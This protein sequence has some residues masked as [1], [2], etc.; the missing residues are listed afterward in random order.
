MRLVKG[1]QARTPRSVIESVGRCEGGKRGLRAQCTSGGS[2]RASVKIIRLLALAA[3]FALQGKKKGKEMVRKQTR[4]RCGMTSPWVSKKDGM[5]TSQESGQNPGSPTSPGC[6][7]TLKLTQ[8][9]RRA[10]RP[11]KHATSWN[12]TPGR[13]GKIPRH[14]DRFSCP[15]GSIVNP[16]KDA[17]SCR[18]VGFVRKEGKVT[19][20]RLKGKVD[21]MP[22]LQ[23]KNHP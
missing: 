13:V 8:R 3:A 15:A 9:N 20:A 7:R 17:P 4:R 5:V 21:V 10:R 23:G 11:S 18:F 1:L 22:F 14:K 19:H 6:L 16:F 2:S 12:Q